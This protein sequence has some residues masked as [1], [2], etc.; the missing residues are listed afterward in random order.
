M[1]KKDGIFLEGIIISSKL[2]V[3]NVGKEE[4][5]VKDS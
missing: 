3:L 4:L 1:D 5:K 2:L